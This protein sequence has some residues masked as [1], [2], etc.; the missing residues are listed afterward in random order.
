MKKALGILAAITT[1]L[2]IGG[3]ANAD[4]TATIS[5][6]IQTPQ[7]LS[8]SINTGEVGFNF[9]APGTANVSADQS[10]GA[11]TLLPN[12]YSYSSHLGGDVWYAPDNSMVPQFQV[13]SNE[14]SW[15][16]NATVPYS[17]TLPS[18]YLKV[19]TERVEATRT[20]TNP[21]NDFTAIGGTTPT[22]GLVILGA[23]G[24][25]TFKL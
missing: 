10:F 2:A 12:A 22:S 21:F 17:L 5:F 11:S 13:T 1:A 16:I 8:L 3:A 24:T 20:T 18:T 6:R 9:A 15:H 19:K 25:D 4:T 7:V 23:P 14:G